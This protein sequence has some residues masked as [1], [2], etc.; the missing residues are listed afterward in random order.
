MKKI[1]L[2]SISMILAVSFLLPIP[3]TVSAQNNSLS[4][5]TPVTMALNIKVVE[6]ALW[7]TKNPDDFSGES[8][9]VLVGS[10]RYPSRVL[11]FEEI[12]EEEDAQVVQVPVEYLEQFISDP[13]LAL[14]DIAGISTA[15]STSFFPVKSR[16]LDCVDPMRTH[17]FTRPVITI[18]LMSEQTIQEYFQ[19]RKLCHIVNSLWTPRVHP[20]VERHIHID[21]AY[22]E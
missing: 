13:D 2:F 14:R 4:M 7:Q 8:F 9:D 18:P 1:I 19:E 22:S 17:P 20:E 12:V 11:E 3:M 16:I 6:F 5:V 15:G 10:E 21:L